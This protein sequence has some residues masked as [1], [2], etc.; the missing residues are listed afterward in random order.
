MGV[1]GKNDGFVFLD[2]LL[3]SERQ[4]ELFVNGKGAPSPYLNVYANTVV[5]Y[6]MFS[7]V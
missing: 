2:R 5:L 6:K 3:C 1:V 7:S 4:P